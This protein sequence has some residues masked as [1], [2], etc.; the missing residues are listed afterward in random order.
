MHRTLSEWVV[1]RNGFYYQRTSDVPFT[2]TV[3][4]TTEGSMTNGKREGEW[5]FYYKNKL[6]LKANYGSGKR[7]GELVRYNKNGK[8]KSK[9]TYKNGKR[10]GPWVHYKVE[11]GF[12]KKLTGTFKNGKKVSDL[13]IR[14][15]TP[16]K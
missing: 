11:G 12:F 16:K 15:R 13:P 7:E 4:G 5:R 14:I 3:S 6:W 9:G 1:K 8:L 10:D 2:G